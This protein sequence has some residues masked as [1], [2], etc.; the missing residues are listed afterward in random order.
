M[1]PNEKRMGGTVDGEWK[2]SY[3]SR[4]QRRWERKMGIVLDPTSVGRPST[5]AVGPGDPPGGG[6][7]LLDEVGPVRGFVSVAPVSVTW[8]DRVGR[9]EV[10]LTQG[11]T[12]SLQVQY[13]WTILRLR[14]ENR[15]ANRPP[16]RETGLEMPC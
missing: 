6:N 8:K 10:K 15:P 7:F 12:V 5:P 14:W 16:N 2:F 11:L 13:S 1:V 9:F 4:R 3:G